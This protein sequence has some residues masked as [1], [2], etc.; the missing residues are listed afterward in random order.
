MNHSAGPA[1][2]NLVDGDFS[3]PPMSPSDESPRFP[4]FPN[5]PATVHFVNAAHADVKSEQ[6]STTGVVI[7]LAGSAVVCQS[8]TQTS[9]SGIE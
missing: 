1:S 7:F 8:K 5:D 4:T 9:G 6:K 3:D 2:I